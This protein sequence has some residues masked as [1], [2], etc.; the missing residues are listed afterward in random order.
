MLHASNFACA[1]YLLPKCL[2]ITSQALPSI[3]PA[4]VKHSV[5]IACQILCA[6]WQVIVKHLACKYQA[7]TK[8][9]ACDSTAVSSRWQLF[10][11]VV[12][13]MCWPEAVNRNVYNV[14]YHLQAYS[15]GSKCLL[16]KHYLVRFITKVS[17]L[18]ILPCFSRNSSIRWVPGNC[19]HT[20]KCWL[21]IGH[22]LPG[23]LIG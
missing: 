22:Y 13:V 10:D 12:G 16:L 3:C 8:W 17:L 2:T 18:F 14:R 9:I 20:H 21:L 11:R 7:H 5:T 6:A 23:Y 15:S 4:S 1:W 19:S